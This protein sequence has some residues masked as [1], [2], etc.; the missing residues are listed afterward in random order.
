MTAMTK[1]AELT[2][3]PPPPASPDWDWRADFFAQAA[4]H[5]ETKAQQMLEE[6]QRY[7]GLSEQARH[8]HH[9]GQHR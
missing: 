6:A 3:I 5:F 8:L 2:E 1:F 9:I 4:A 7:R